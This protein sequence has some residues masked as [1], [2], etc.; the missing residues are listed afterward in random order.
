[1]TLL[2]LS[3]LSA[4]SALK[5][6]PASCANLTA[7]FPDTLDGIECWTLQ[8]LRTGKMGN[9]IVTAA[10][11]ASACCTDPTCTLYN[12][13]TTVP[14]TT[15]G[16]WV[17]HD[18]LGSHTCRPVNGW[19]GRGGRGEAPLPPPPPPCAAPTGS[20]ALCLRPCS[21]PDDG[22]HIH[23]GNA[24]HAPG[25]SAGG[26]QCPTPLSFT[27][28]A[29]AAVDPSGTRVGADSR[30]LLRSAGAGLPM[31]RWYPV[32]GEIHLARVPASEWREQ[33]M[34]MKGGG[35]DMVAVYVFWIHHE[36]ARGVFNFTGRRDIRRFVM[37]AKEVG[38]KVMMRIGPWD[39][40]EARNGAHPDWVLTQCGKVRTTDPKYL[41][42][43]EGWYAALAG[44]LTG[45]Y[46][47]DGGPILMAQVDN[48]TPD[49]GFL[50]A[51]KALARKH[52]I[53]PPFYT[54]TGW[55]TPREG[56]P[57]DYPM[58]PFFG[59]YAD[60][61][62]T[63]Q[64]A[65]SVSTGAYTFGAHQ[66]GVVGTPYLGVEM[67]G[68]MAAAYNHRVHMFSDDMPSMHTVDV[69][70][71]FN[72]LGF[73]MY[74]GGNNPHST[75]HH[76]RDDPAT[77]LQESSF[78]PAGAQNPM[79]SESYD[80]FAPLG[81]FGQPRRHYHQMRRLHNMVKGWGP[82]IADSTTSLPQVV[83]GP[84]DNATVRWS[85]RATNKSEGFIF[86]NNYQRL[87]PQQA[88]TGVRFHM[89]LLDGVG[90]IAIPSA[91]S[92]PIQIK[93]GLWFVLPFNVPL[94]PSFAHIPGYAEGGLAGPSIGWATAQLQA[95]LD[96]AETWGRGDDKKVEYIFFLEIDG[97]APEVA[98]G[99]VN[100]TELVLPAGG[101]ATASQEG[102]YT[103]LRGI[104]PG[105]GAFA[106]VQIGRGTCTLPCPA[107]TVR[108]VMLPWSMRDRVYTVPNLNCDRSKYGLAHPRPTVLISEEEEDAGGED[109]YAGMLLH[110]SSDPCTLHLRTRRTNTSF[111]MVPQQES[112]IKPLC[113]LEDEPNDT[114]VDDNQCEGHF[115][116]PDGVFSKVEVG[117]T[118]GLDDARGNSLVPNSS[119][120]P[121]PK[122]AL[123]SSAQPPRHVQINPHSHK[124]QEPTAAE[125]ELAAKYT[126]TLSFPYPAGDTEGC[127][128]DHCPRGWLRH[129]NASTELT[130]AI[131]Y[132]GDAAR[133][134]YKDRL[135]TDNWYSGY[136]GDGALQVGLTYLA[137]ENPGILEDGAELSLWVL[138]LKKSTLQPAADPGVPEGKV[139][140]QQA[141]WPDFGGASSVL[142]VT[143]LRWLVT[144]RV[145]LAIFA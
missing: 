106:E 142:N 34:R 42:C 51:L 140:L 122:L 115:Y 28:E 27:P 57:A 1:M 64:M 73:Y 120:I 114:C 56:Y 107:W 7:V 99:R 24:R 40:G 95:R 117:P 29:S 74:H 61:F 78:Q 17:A 135:L 37:T 91:G 85:A 136:R 134:Y 47:A 80:F 11:C 118:P 2:L 138:P 39:H 83:A 18:K 14:L 128:A 81:E 36:E 58:L 43:V 66:S 127:T 67:G 6:Q 65:P 69:A 93:A 77:T 55:P 105:T 103:V 97:I 13:N 41:G 50:L 108:L 126:I 48:E 87:S 75:V 119:A 109:A 121:P 96:A 84:T 53:E 145:P 60:Q 71:G 15:T 45:L 129:N 90:T 30:S 88:K 131:D 137:G 76:D 35:L 132:Q 68:G 54:K 5:Q 49:W 46:H 52:G 82:L 112:F 70:N 130:L 141:F 124:A 8:A 133:V 16:C 26:S 23:P 113:C 116:Q 20:L 102:A 19:T 86:V 38:L 139:F 98:L 104:T 92:P 31:Q 89:T 25:P 22:H 44:E 21:H 10:G 144:A 33:L 9:P 94:I 62:W 12:F 123:V 100:H 110:D 101:T 32:S 72:M 111:W 143:A 63:N 3:L 79:P 59:G 125:W 4:S